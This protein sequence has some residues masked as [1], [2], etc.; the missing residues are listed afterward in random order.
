[1]RSVARSDLAASTFILEQLLC[2]TDLPDA[3]FPAGAV[4]PAL[5][6]YFAFQVG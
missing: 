6:K 5:Q 3:P 2:P 4:Q 1:M